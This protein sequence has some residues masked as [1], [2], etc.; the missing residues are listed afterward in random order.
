MGILNI[1]TSSLIAFQRAMYVTGNN[2]ANYQTAGYSKQNIHF[3]SQPGQRFGGIQFGSGVNVGN[4]SRSY[5]DYATRMVRDTGSVKTEYETYFNQA[6]QID[7]LLSQDGNSISKGIENFMNALS[8]VN[9]NPD[10]I[11][12]RGVF[13]SQA[14]SMVDRYK[15]MQSEL[16]TLQQSKNQELQLTIGD[17]NQ[18][19]AQIAELNR[20]VTNNPDS[21]EL[22][23]QRDELIRQLSEKI[24]VTVVKQGDGSVNV[25]IGTGEML[26]SGTSYRSLSAEF[27]PQGMFEP[28]VMLVGGGGKINITSAVTSGQLG[29]LL[30]YEKSILS[31]A[32]QV[33][34]QMAIGTAL[35]FNAQH[36]LGLDLNNQLGKDLFTDFNAIDIQK[37]R[38]FS[39]TGNIGTAQMRVAISDINQTQVSDYDLQVVNAAT[40]TVQITRKSDGVVVTQSFSQNPP[41]PPAGAISI[42]GLT[43]NVDDVSQLATGDSY[44]LTPFRDAARDMNLQIS[45]AREVAIAT[46]VRVMKGEQNTGVGN[47]RLDKVFNTTDV[48]KEFRIEFISDTQYNIVNVTDSVTTGPLTF[49]PNTDNAISIPDSI[50]PSY[51]ITISGI[52]KAGDTFTSSFNDS[53]INNNANGLIMSQLATLKQFNNSTES[54][55]DRYSQLISS[56]GTRTHQSQIAAASAQILNEKAIADRESTS[57]VNLDEEAAA[58]VKYQQAYQ[59]AGQLVATVNQMMNTLFDALR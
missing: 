52:P 3:N 19:A 45:T 21:N 40:N 26:V 33:I 15:S 6:T 36:R 8:K 37:N 13:L 38:A 4:V 58:L 54:M 16:D 1:A 18:L 9:D 35:A 5:N 32:S 10:D 20:S 59:A 30:N 55:Y 12:A 34:G 46:P 27:G 53:G 24:N 50:S 57:G 11:S 25:G 29:G 7:T 48:N 56:V 14:K 39:A 47:I 2:I 28:Q 23:D 41:A 42:D 44:T 49:T 51:Q 31:H 22:L 43:L 17:I